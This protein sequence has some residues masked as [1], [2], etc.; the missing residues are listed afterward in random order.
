M[1]D[2]FTYALREH[3]RTRGQMRDGWG[4]QSL[5][6]HMQKTQCSGWVIPEGVKAQADMSYD[7]AGTDCDPQG[8]HVI[9]LNQRL[10]CA[11]GEYRDKTV[12]IDGTFSELLTQLLKIEVPREVTF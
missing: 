6:W 11:C 1:A 3:M 9:R 5:H 8:T 10:S 12:Q 7:F 2:A 4:G